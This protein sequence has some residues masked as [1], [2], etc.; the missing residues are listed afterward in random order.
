MSVMNEDEAAST[1]WSSRVSDPLNFRL[2]RDQLCTTFGS[3][4]DC[5]RQVDF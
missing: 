2:L 3:K 1:R 4:V 5:A